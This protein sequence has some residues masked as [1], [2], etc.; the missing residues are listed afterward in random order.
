[1]SIRVRHQLLPIHPEWPKKRHS[2][3]I[4]SVD[5]YTKL[6]RALDRTATERQHLLWLLQT[7]TIGEGDSW[8]AIYKI[9]DH[10]FWLE[11]P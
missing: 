8:G 10:C 9:G 3:E 4:I 7:K 2:V 6:A 11:R 5:K 1:M